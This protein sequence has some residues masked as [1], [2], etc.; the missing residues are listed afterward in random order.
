MTKVK[1]GLETHVQ[2]NTQSKLFCGCRNPVGIAEEIAPN[3][4]T[5]PTCLGL[6]GSKPVANEEAVRMAIKVALAL[7]CRIQGEIL[8][9]RKT[10]FYP[11]M[12]KNF[13]ITQYEIPLA[14]E[15]SIMMGGK[16]IRI[17]RLH[18]EEDPARLVHVE[19]AGGGYTLADYNRAGIP[20]IEIVT[21][22]DFESPAEARAYL[23]K[24]VTMLEY[25]GVYDSASKA[26]LKSD[27][28]ISL[29][30]GERIEV[31]NITGT[32]EIEEA[33]NYEIVRQKNTIKR[34]Q[35]VSR[36]TRSWDP[37]LKITQRLREKEE[38]ED[39]GYIADTDLS[40][41]EIKEAMISRIK[42]SIPELP[43]ERYRRF[44]RQYRVSEKSAESLVSEK[45]TADLFEELAK[46]IDAKIAAGWVSGY[47]K[48]TLNWHGISFRQSGIRKEWME[49]LLKLFQEGKITDRGAETVIRK[50]AEEKVQPKEVIKKYGFER[51][52]VDKDIKNK[53]KTILDKNKKAAEDY[54]S[55]EEKALHFLVGLVIK[56]TG[57]KLDAND[58]RRLILKLIKDKRQN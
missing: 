14:M 53:I 17:K 34:G 25:L 6:P 30:W 40:I 39:Y 49:R 2:L 38:E 29:E 35:T 33:L 5:C 23:Q 3:S 28:N 19:G 24:L 43:E 20:L 55:G 27:A 51:V 37:S 54:R 13:Q 46:K 1:I 12:S 4:L 48:K 42:K 26:V 9:S 10:Y 44:I 45:D 7:R 15:S 57:G 31:K 41:I 21:E 58:A 11:D 8:F 22:P 16:R 36:E 18:I 47:L 32:K 50:M 52:E 56:E